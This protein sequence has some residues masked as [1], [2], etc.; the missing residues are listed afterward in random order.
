MYTDF[1]FDGKSLS[2][3]GYMICS[4]DSVGIEKT[5]VSN[6]TYNTVKAPFSNVSK[7]TS[8]SYGENLQTSNPI[9]ICKNTCNF[10]STLD[11]TADEISELSK[12]LC[13]R[14]Y[15]WF[16]FVDADN[17]MDEIYY[18]AQINMN[19]VMLGDRCIGL[20]LLILTNRPYGLTPEITI[21][22]QIK[23][24]KNNTLSINVYSDEEGYIYPDVTIRMNEAGTLKIINSYNN[25]ET[26]VTNCSIGEIINF[27]GD[28]LQIESSNENHIISDCYNYN[29]PALC[30]EFN[31]TTNIFTLNLNCDVEFKYRGIRKVG[32]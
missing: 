18:E 1:I 12:W 15:K 6:I 10:N 14:D 17:G 4:F 8:T 3:Y 21:K 23:R 11:I 9:G 32:L 31:K 22:S 20:E 28:I 16:N 30:N 25:S 7:K 13:R 19:K 2:D 5:T 29:F 24:S 26:I 27:Y